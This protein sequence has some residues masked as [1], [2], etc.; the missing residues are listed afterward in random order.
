MQETRSGELSPSGYSQGSRGKPTHFV[1]NDTG[2]SAGP[3]TCR[4]NDSSRFQKCRGCTGVDTFY[5]WA[6][7]TNLQRLK[8]ILAIDEE[9]EDATIPLRER[10]GLLDSAWRLLPEV[11][12]EDAASAT[13]LKAELQ[14]VVGP[15]GPSSELIEEWKKLFP[16]PSARTTRTKRAAAAREEDDA[17]SEETDEA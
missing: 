3:W 17:D 5:C 1:R 10:I 7:W 2:S 12:R 8:A 4:G 11:A 13:R 15:E 14:A 6:G 16:P 9:L